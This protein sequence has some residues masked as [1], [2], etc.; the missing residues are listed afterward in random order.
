MNTKDK[1]LHGFVKIGEIPGGG[2]I[3]TVAVLMTAI[4]MGIYTTIKDAFFSQ[5]KKH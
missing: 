2:I 5:E 3:L 4:G 1:L